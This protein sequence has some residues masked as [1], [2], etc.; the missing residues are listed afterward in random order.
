MMAIYN[1]LSK[2]IT[3]CFNCSGQI[4]STAFDVVGKEIF[5]AGSPTGKPNYTRYIIGSEPYINHFGR[6]GFDIYNGIL[7][8][9]LGTNIMEIIDVGSG[10]TI[11]SVSVVTGHGN[12]VSF[13]QEKLDTS[14]EFPLLYISKDQGDP[15]DVYIYHVER[16]NQNHFTFSLVKTLRWELSAV[17]Y[18]ANAAY[19]YEN[20]IMYMFSYHE[21]SYMDTGTNVMEI[22]KWD[23]NNLTTNQDGTF[24]PAFVSK[25][26]TDYVI[27]LRAGQQFHDGLIWTGSGSVR[28][29]YAID[30]S[31]GVQKYTFPQNIQTEFEGEAFLDDFKMVVGYNNGSNPGFYLY[32]F[33]NL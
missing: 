4:V 16:D 17:G 21:N 11:D 8:L 33:G 20:R 26:T 12:S 23:M 15:C 19:D 5:N 30:P 18:Y 29:I 22:S 14:D 32:T 10:E 6:Q 9:A 24:T 28:K 27:P 1:Y 31:T 13:S 25:I 7:F 2:E 3:S